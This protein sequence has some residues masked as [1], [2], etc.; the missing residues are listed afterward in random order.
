MRGLKADISNYAGMN[1]SMWWAV[2]K[3]RFRGTQVMFDLWILKACLVSMHLST[4][5]SMRPDETEIDV[6]QRA[7][8]LDKKSHQRLL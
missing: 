5:I 6:E 7:I 3:L 1:V 8:T 4:S 2:L